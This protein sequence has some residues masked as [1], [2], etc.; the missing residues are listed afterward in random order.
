MVWVPLSKITHKNKALKNKGNLAFAKNMPLMPLCLFELAG[1]TQNFPVVFVKEGV[2]TRVVGLVGLRKGESLFVGAD[3]QW[4]GQYAPAH[5]RSF[6]FRLGKLNDNQATLMVFDNDDTLGD[7]ADGQRLFDDNGEATAS[8]KEAMRLVTAIYNDQRVMARV[9]SLLSELDL[10]IPFSIRYED[11]EV[12]NIGGLLKVDYDK[13]R[14]LSQGSFET[15]R[16]ALALEVIYA[17]IFSMQTMPILGKMW[18]RRQKSDAKLKEL[19]QT[20]FDDGQDAPLNF[21]LT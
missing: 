10:L 2:D 1:M 12:V 16:Q 21:D 18:G 8:I 7:N 11:D 17:H 5:L 9:G 6:P 15:L 20:I 14:G 13:L 19:G 4:L 3:G